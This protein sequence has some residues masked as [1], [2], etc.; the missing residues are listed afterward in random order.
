MDPKSPDAPAGAAPT[1]VSA[2]PAPA[3]PVG[4][5][6]H[7]CEVFLLS[8]GDSTLS[9]R[10]A[11]YTGDQAVLAGFTAGLIDPPTAMEAIK[12]LRKITA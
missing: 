1:V 9:D 3:D 10:E 12:R 7:A 8:L 11:A 6:A 5:F 2:P 4:A